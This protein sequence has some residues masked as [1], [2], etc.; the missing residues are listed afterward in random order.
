M[1]KSDTKYFFLSVIEC[2][3]FHE[4][5]SVAKFMNINTLRKKVQIQNMIKLAVSCTQKTVVSLT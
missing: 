3:Y 4:N 5:I 2:I 1:V